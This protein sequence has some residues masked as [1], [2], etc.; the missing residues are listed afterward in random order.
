MN[1]RV[2]C[3]AP[4]FNTDGKN[5][6]SGA[7][8]PEARAFVRLHGNGS[9]L[10]LFDNTKPMEQRRDQ[11]A[12]TLQSRAAITNAWTGVAFF[13]HGWTSGIQAGFRDADVLQLAA[14]ISKLCG[15]G[16]PTVP[17]YCCSTGGDVD[18]PANDT[19]GAGDHSFADRLRDQLCRL[20]K[21]AVRVMAH[22][23]VAHTTENPNARFFDGNHSPVGGNGGYA[24]VG[25][26]TE[27]WSPWVNS[28][29][30]GDLRFRF[31]FMSIAEIHA[32]LAH[33]AQAAQVVV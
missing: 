6:A 30:S 2:L 31:P 25:P 7:F 26:K 33:A 4:L 29:K 17:L 5:D 11:V 32:E 28:L 27:L 13:T 12:A 21:T 24:V 20:G 22:S 10:V 18:G 23:T 1:Q 16:T 15:A 19:P 8:Q 9:E 3:F 14:W